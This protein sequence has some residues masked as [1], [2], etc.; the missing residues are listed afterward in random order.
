MGRLRDIFKAC[1]FVVTTHSPLV[2]GEVPARCVRF[3]EYQDGKPVVSLSG[4]QGS[5]NLYALTRSNALL[6][7]P[8]GV[9]C[10]PASEEVDIWLLE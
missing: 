7:L 5:A 8:S 4:H 3:L 9:K 6:I 2:L 1:Q 10:V